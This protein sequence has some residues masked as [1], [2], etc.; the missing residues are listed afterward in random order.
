M[1]FQM[2]YKMLLIEQ[3]QFLMSHIY[4]SE[5]YLEAH[6]TKKHILGGKQKKSFLYFNIHLQGNHSGKETPGYQ[7]M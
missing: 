2:E 5:G 4:V 1:T 7:R 3:K 6:T